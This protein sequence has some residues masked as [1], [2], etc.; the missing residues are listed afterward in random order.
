MRYLEFYNELF[1]CKN[2]DE[3]FDFLLKNLKPSNRL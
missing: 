2:E 1:G 3:V